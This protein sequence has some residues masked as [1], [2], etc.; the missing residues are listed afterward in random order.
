LQQLQWL[1]QLQVLNLM[2]VG[3]D[4]LSCLRTLQQLTALTVRVLML[5]ALL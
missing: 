5:A 2:A 3:S 4:D 1:P